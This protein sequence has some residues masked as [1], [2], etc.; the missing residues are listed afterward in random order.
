M[1][2][3]NDKVIKILL[4]RSYEELHVCI[5]HYLR[6]SREGNVGNR[7]TFHSGAGHLSMYPDEEATYANVSRP[8]RG[9]D[10]C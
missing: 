9:M 2:D 1:N 10:L 5:E 8:V 6:I 4:Q 3:M 7:S